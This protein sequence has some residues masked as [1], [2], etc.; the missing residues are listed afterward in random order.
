MSPINDLIWS[1][2]ETNIQNFFLKIG[3][4]C[5]FCPTVHWCDSSLLHSKFQ[6]WQMRSL[7]TLD[8]YRILK[9]GKFEIVSLS[10]IP[11]RPV[12]FTVFWILTWTETRTYDIWITKKNWH[13]EKQICTTREEALNSS[14]IEENGVYLSLVPP[15]MVSIEMPQWAALFFKWV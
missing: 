5:D 1:L 14:S 4:I 10:Q 7:P 6:S 2:S 15:K 12:F 11:I 13:D 9:G 3:Q 8:P